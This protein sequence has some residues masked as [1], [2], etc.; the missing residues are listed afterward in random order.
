MNDLIINEGYDFLPRNNFHA[1]KA[2]FM[3]QPAEKCG[4]GALALPFA[5]TTP[6]GVQ[7]RKITGISSV[8]LIHSHNSE[9]AAA[10]P[11]VYLPSTPAFTGFEAT[12][13]NVNGDSIYTSHHD[14]ITVNTVNTIAADR[15]MT[16][17]LK[18]N[19]PYFIKT[20]AETQIAS[21]SVI[22][23]ANI[24][25]GIRIY[26]EP[27]IDRAYTVFA[28]SLYSAHQALASHPENSQCTQFADSI[29]AYTHA[30]DSY[31]FDNN[32]D[33]TNAAKQLGTLIQ[34]FLSEELPSAIYNIPTDSTNNY[35]TNAPVRYYSIDGTQLTAPRRGI[36]II[37][38]GNKVRKVK[39]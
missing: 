35:D 28:D 4:W 5:A 16:L 19:L 11:F 10:T 33:I 37:K 39:R 22:I 21:F 31:A 29:A 3:T 15:N 14:S 27:T 34:Q 38:Q 32:K 9:I 6:K 24:A 2:K 1:A 17:G 26:N 12:D 25:N 13:V 8:K 18:N 30:F 7:V 36:I 20:E 23:N